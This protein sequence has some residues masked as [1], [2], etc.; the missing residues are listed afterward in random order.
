MKTN[1]INTLI[2]AIILI[3]GWSLFTVL[4][5][6][7]AAKKNNY[8]NFS[9]IGKSKQYLPIAPENYSSQRNYPVYKGTN[10]IGTGTPVSRQPA[11]VSGKSILDNAATS[12]TMIRGGSPIGSSDRAIV[13]SR[14]QIENTNLNF[15]RQNIANPTISTPFSKSMKIDADRNLAV[16]SAPKSISGSNLSSAGSGM[17]KAFGGGDE[18]D[19]FE[20]GGGNENQN[21]YNDVPVGDGFFLLL[22]MS[23]I[24]FLI[25]F[26]KDIKSFLTH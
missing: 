20:E 9:V 19:D 5:D 25:K 1:I 17:M 16:A 6:F 15:Q 14:K 10:R 24:Y 11:T 4:Q 13:A 3:V 21:F 22:L 8:N 12:T 7:S 18:G 23:I 26:R 2:V